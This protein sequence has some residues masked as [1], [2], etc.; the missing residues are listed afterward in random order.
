MAYMYA[1][2]NISSMELIGSSLSNAFQISEAVYGY[3]IEDVLK[4]GHEIRGT[5]GKF[6]RIF[7]PITLDQLIIVFMVILPTD[8]VL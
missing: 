8:M 5:V 6:I 2:S 4:I 7:H 1:L 3:F